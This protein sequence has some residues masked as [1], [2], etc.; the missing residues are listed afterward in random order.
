MRFTSAAIL[1]GF[2]RDAARLVLMVR[3]ELRNGQRNA[4]RYDRWERE[5]AELARHS[6]FYRASGRMAA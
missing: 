6:E 2:N 1:A 5:T 3:M 4:W